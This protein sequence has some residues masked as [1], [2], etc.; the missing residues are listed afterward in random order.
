MLAHR[1]KLHCR[2]LQSN[3]T[4]V[5]APNLPP[6]QCLMPRGPSQVVGQGSTWADEEDHIYDAMCDNGCDDVNGCW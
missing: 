6:V 4:L 5:W 2:V 1:L 3:T